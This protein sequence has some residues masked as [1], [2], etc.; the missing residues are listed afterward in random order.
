M[1][2][3]DRQSQLALI[4]DCLEIFAENQISWTYWNY[5]NLDFG[6]ISQ[7]EQLFAAHPPYCN[8]ERTDHELLKLL[9]SY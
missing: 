8:P 2:G 9:Q 6:I 1:G 3:P 7:G 5:K 4:K